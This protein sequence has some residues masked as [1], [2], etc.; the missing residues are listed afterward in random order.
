MKQTIVCDAHSASSDGK[1]LTFLA[2]SGTRMTNGFPVDLQTL[3]AP[4]DGGLLKP[5]AEL[6]DSDELTLPLFVDRMPSI[7]YQAGIIEKL[8]ITDEGLMARARLS[9][10]EPGEDIRK[11]A[12]EGMLTN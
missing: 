6:A 4:V 1:M 3:L 12:S 5:V 10:N 11:L 7:T 9:S 2:N 8:W